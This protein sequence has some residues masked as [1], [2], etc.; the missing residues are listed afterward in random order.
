MFEVEK[1]LNQALELRVVPANI[2]RCI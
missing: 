1:C 2:C